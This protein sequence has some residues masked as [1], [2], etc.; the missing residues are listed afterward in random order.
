MLDLVRKVVVKPEWDR[1]GL[2]LSCWQRAELQ[3]DDMLQ[4]KKNIRSQLLEFRRIS[5]SHK[6][7]K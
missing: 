3:V 6:F 1:V 2:S 7:I 5:N 4:Y